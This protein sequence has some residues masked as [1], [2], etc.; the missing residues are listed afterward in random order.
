MTSF[1]SRV[2]KP[3]NYKF[4][5]NKIMNILII[6]CIDNSEMFIKLTMMSNVYDETYLAKLYCTIRTELN[7]GCRNIKYKP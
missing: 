7:I 1:S 3:L 4:C 2:S 5:R 6:Q